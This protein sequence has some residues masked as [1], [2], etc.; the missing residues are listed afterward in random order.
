MIRGA[1]RFERGAQGVSGGDDLGHG[2]GLHPLELIRGHVGA[3]LGFSD[4]VLAQTGVEER[5]GEPH[6]QTITSAL[7]ADGRQAG[8]IEVPRACQ[9]LFIIDEHARA[10]VV[11]VLLVVEVLV[12]IDRPDFGAQPDVVTGVES[13]PEGRS[14]KIAQA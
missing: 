13:I 6:Q 2:G 3:G 9:V 14:N 1:V 11:A 5:H 8:H 10:P 12:Q 7:L 4:L